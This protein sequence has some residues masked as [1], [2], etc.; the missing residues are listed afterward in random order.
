M[1][2]T[3]ALF[4]TIATLAAA[5]PSPNA[6]T[7]AGLLSARQG[8]SYGCVCQTTGEGEGPSPDTAR[9][10]TGGTPVNGGVVC[11]PPY[12]PTI[13]SFWAG[14]TGHTCKNQARTDSRIC[15]QTCADM[16]FAAAV[17]FVGCCTLG[18][19]CTVPSGCDPIPDP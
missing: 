16:N 13:C 18:H 7:N 11:L 5:A 17:S 8:C 19:I 3:T 6:E 12:Q 1:K 4:L 15:T 10:C 14:V 2:T 9:C